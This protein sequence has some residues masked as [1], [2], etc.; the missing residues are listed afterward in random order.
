MTDTP[1]FSINV[2]Q[3]QY[4]PLDGTEVHAIVSV[5]SSKGSSLTA[6]T[7]AEAAEVIIVDTSGSMM[8]NEIVAARRAA[9]SAIDTLRDGVKFA[10]VA[11]TDRATMVYP[12]TT[13]LATVTAATRQE[14]KDAVGQ[15]DAYGGTAMGE[16]LNLAATL[17]QPV[18]DAIKHAILLT[19]GQNNEPASVLNQAL[20]RCSGLFVCDC[21]G[22]GVGWNVEE[23]RKIS[24]ALLGEVEMIADPQDMEEDFRKLTSKAMGKAVA[25][26]ALRLWT[27]QTASVQYVKQV[28]PTVEDLTERRSEPASAPQAGDYPTGSWGDESRDYHICISVPPGTPGRE[29]RA[30]WVRLVVAGAEEQVLAS[31]NILAEWTEDEE[32]STRIHPSVAHYTGQEELSNAIQEGLRARKAGDLETATH[33]LGRAVELAHSSGHEDMTTRLGGVVDVVD[34]A[35]GTV[36]LKQQVSEQEEMMLDTASVRTARIGPARG[37]SA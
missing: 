28:A 12:R 34:A 3:N 36:R 37:T 19:D 14:A 22:V 25:D 7:A 17:F 33:R 21:R 35:S 16:W 5:T 8:G 15:L 29:M 13:E 9:R 11:G 1:S 2:D 30:G 18:P 4:L 23:L 6:G 31:G 20:E 24:S 32:R 10:I 26:V 27:P